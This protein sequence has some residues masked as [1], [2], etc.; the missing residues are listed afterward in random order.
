MVSIALTYSWNRSIET[1]IQYVLENFYFFNY[2]FCLCFTSCV[3]VVVPG[4]S[5]S[6]KK[7]LKMTCFE[8][9]TGGAHQ[10]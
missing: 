1:I 5:P 2:S 8:S 7:Y 3:I 10:L 4:P 6:L 9:L